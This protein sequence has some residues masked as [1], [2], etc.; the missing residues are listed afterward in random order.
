MI[1]KAVL[2]VVSLLVVIGVGV[3]LAR[4][5]MMTQEI[6]NFLSKL[7]F[8]VTLPC[9]IIVNMS[10]YFSADMLREA[11]FSLLLPMGVMVLSYALARLLCIL[12]RVPVERRGVTCAMFSFS[13]SILTGLPINNA[14][15]GEGS[16][17]YA[18][19]YFVCNSFMFWTIGVW[20]IRRDAEKM[21]GATTKE[22]FFSWKT[23]RKMMPPSL[24][25]FLLMIVLVLVDVTIPDVFMDVFKYLGN[26]STTLS[27]L[28]TGYVLGSMQKN[29]ISLGKESLLAVFGKYI[30][31][32]LVTFVLL[33]SLSMPSLMKNVYFVQSA[34]PVMAQ[35]TIV[36]AAYGADR[37]YAA[38]V[39]AITTVASLAVM[40][41]IATIITLIGF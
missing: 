30:F 1:V 15:F 33:F 17:P 4:R 18:L 13:N 21:N 28:F 9:L 37:K 39:F 40:P 6:A 23:L 36:A 2:S 3:V 10:Q 25:T 26:M 38:S 29:D 12:F 5:K 7:V 41:L 31:T 24:V 32:P 34:M 35:T 27:M 19:F 11:G 22:P 8:G 16:M 20:G 14:L